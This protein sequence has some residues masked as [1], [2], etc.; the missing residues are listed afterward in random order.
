MGPQPRP[1]S[2]PARQCSA[3]GEGFQVVGVRVRVREA[4]I[5]NGGMMRI[6][7]QPGIW[8]EIFLKLHAHVR[9]Y[10]CVSHEPSQLLISRVTST[11]GR[12]GREEFSWADDNAGVPAALSTEPAIAGTA[13]VSRTTPARHAGI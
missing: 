2:A 13:F 7:P 6:C 3:R 9:R 5:W 12:F 8:S 1:A 11:F 10:P 4:G